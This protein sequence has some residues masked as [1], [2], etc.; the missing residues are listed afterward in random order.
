MVLCLIMGGAF[1]EQVCLRKWTATHEAAKVSG[2]GSEWLTQKRGCCSF[3]KNLGF[4]L[5]KEGCPAILT[6]LLRHGAKVTSMDGHGVTPMGIAAE[7]GNA[8]ALEILIQHGEKQN[9]YL[10][11][12]FLVGLVV[13][14]FGFYSSTSHPLGGDVN[15][16]ASNGDTIIYDAA[17]SGNLDS[18]ELLLR[19]GAN[20]NVASY[21]HQL[22]IHRAAYEGHIL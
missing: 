8:E 14:H 12:I 17:G 19:H 15:A 13:I 9:L 1:V 22:P 3:L 2:S 5:K 6:L 4:F 7:Y 16:Q 11:F 20:P 10:I 21:A 18:V